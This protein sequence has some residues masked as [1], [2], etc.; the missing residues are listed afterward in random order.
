[1][2]KLTYNYFYWLKSFEFIAHKTTETFFDFKV[3]LKLFINLFPFRNSMQNTIL[4]I[5]I[6]ALHPGKL[7]ECAAQ[8]KLS[9]SIHR[10]TIKI[11]R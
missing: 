3:S 7:F 9:R 6:L 4:T 8:H 1:M 5:R 2:A 11:Q 10:K